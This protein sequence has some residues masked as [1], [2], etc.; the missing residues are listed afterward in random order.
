M[1][2]VGFMRTNICGGRYDFSV[3]YNTSY[4]S[5]NTNTRTELY[6]LL[7]HLMFVVMTTVTYK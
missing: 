6:N 1:Y 3:C 5:F 4:L 2:T 7:D